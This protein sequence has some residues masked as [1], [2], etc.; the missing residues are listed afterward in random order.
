[1]TELD[2]VRWLNSFVKTCKMTKFALTVNLN[3]LSLTKI[4]VCSSL[5]QFSGGLNSEHWWTELFEVLISYSSVLEWS[6]HIAIAMSYGPTSSKRN[7]IGKV[8]GIL[9]VFGIKPPQYE[10][11]NMLTKMRYKHLWIL[12]DILKAGKLW[13]GDD[14]VVDDV[15][16]PVVRGHWRESRKSGEAF[17]N[18]QII[19]GGSVQK[20]NAWKGLTHVSC[21]MLLYSK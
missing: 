1:M 8:I 16:H 4:K 18:H 20:Y 6:V 17:L 3:R 12:E 14:Q 21:C 15:R 5:N 7:A 13:E 9:Y 10:V 11:K 2:Y 19:L